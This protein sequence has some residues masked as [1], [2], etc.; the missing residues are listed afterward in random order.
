[1]KILYGIQTT[2]NGHLT[3]AKEVI[4]I[5]NKRAEVDVI[6]SGPKT[7][8]I[9]LNHPIKH[10]YRGLTFFYTKKGEIHWLKTLFKNN[11]F[12]LFI[13]IFHCPLDS[14]DLILNDFEPVTAWSCYLKNKK[15]VALSNQYSL[16][17]DKGPKLKKRFQTTLKMLR[18]FAPAT[19]GYGLHFKKFDDNIFLPII[20][21]KIRKVKV[22]D[23]GYFLVYL[24]S[25]G[26][27]EIKNVL[28][29]FPNSNWVVFSPEIEK[30]ELENNIQWEPINETTFL[31]NIASCRGVVTSAGFSTLSEAMY[32][33]KP[34]LT[35]PIASQIEQAYN[36]EMIREMGGKVI[37]KF[38][39]KHKKEIQKWILDPKVIAVELEQ[40]NYEVVDRILLDYIKS[41]LNLDQVRLN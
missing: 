40:K 16:F 1:M 19:Y 17:S 32:L 11:F 15:C 34:I 21:K 22:S 35:T 28:I 41:L 25:Y 33:K 20:R 23:M 37:K 10:H 9:S 27:E 26:I 29:I 18:Y 31:K 13:D 30:S 6:L 2:G 3:R 4:S 8:K 14:Y 36:A 5:L 24:P 39:V 7:N 12:K 38:S